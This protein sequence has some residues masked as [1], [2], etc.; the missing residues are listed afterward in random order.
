MKKYLLSFV[1]LLILLQLLGCSLSVSEPVL[2][3]P[4]VTPSVIASVSPSPSP[5][6]HKTLGPTATP[7]ITQYIPTPSPTIKPTERPTP[8]P[9]PTQRPVPGTIVSMKDAQ[10]SYEELMED[11]NQLMA[12]FPQYLTLR[13]IGQS[14]F[15][16]DIPM[17]VMGDPENPKKILIQGS[18]HAR[19]YI[20]SLLVMKQLE[21][22]CEQYGTG[23]YKDST[24]EQIISECAIYF[25]PMLNPDGVNL[26]IKGLDSVPMEWRAYVNALPGISKL[27][28]WKANGVGVDLNGNF[29]TGWGDLSD[30]PTAPC[31]DGYPGTP[32]SEPESKA[33]QTLCAENAFLNL[34]SYHACG[35]ILYWYYYQDATTEARDLQYALEL[36]GLTGYSLVGKDS[37]SSSTVGLKDWFIARYRKPGFTIEVGKGSYGTPVPY[38]DLYNVWYKNELV[39]IHLAWKECN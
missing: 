11:I 31:S 34:T 16:R 14:V 22:Y 27:S 3:Y 39:P 6:P 26:C 24:Y 9:S 13:T 29:G 8:S 36:K 28:A 15:G 20:T 18:T 1:T 38:K 23:I 25:V 17:I 21:V 19:E 2:T 4:Q 12:K 5:T 33:I 10:Y 37:I 32:F 35:R 30:L 7:G